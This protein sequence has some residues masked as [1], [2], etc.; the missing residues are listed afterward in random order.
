MRARKDMLGKKEE[1]ENERSLGLANVPPCI[2]GKISCD[3]RSHWEI[4]AFFTLKISDKP[5]DWSTPG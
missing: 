3:T 4:Y 1:L 5:K 2:L